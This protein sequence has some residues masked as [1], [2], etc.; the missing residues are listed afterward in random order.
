VTNL[1]KLRRARGLSLR[2]LARLTGVSHP[3]LIRL[4]RGDSWGREKTRA[5]LSEFF[6]LPIHYI[7]R[8]MDN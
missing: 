8:P 7:L 4:E 6:G 3:T 1:R 5:A 2:H